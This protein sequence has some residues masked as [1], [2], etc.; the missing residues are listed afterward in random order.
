MTGSEVASAAERRHRRWVRIAT[1]LANA[2]VGN[3]L[4]AL[5]GGM[6]L[7]VP[8][9]A[10]ERLVVLV[11]LFLPGLLFYA[12]RPGGPGFWPRWVAAVG[13]A[14]WFVVVFLAA[15]FLSW[16]LFVVG[17]SAVMQTGIFDSLFPFFL[18]GAAIWGLILLFFLWTLPRRHLGLLWWLPAAMTASVLCT[19]RPPFLV[20][21]LDEG[22]RAFVVEVGRRHGF[23]DAPPELFAVTKLLPG[24]LEWWRVLDHLRGNSSE[25][26]LRREG[27]ELVVEFQTMDS[28]SRE[29][30]TEV[31]R[32]PVR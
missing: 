31:R 21:R 2:V 15:G 5:F 3:E 26:R 27:N 14:V 4:A 32:Y 8:A 9:P 1:C 30:R 25:V 17:I 24:C 18:V 11:L 22:P 23:L 29:W 10:L 19:G 20:Q 28:K 7:R 6:S 13:A 12:A 16:V